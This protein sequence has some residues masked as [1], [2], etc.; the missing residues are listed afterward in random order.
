MFYYIFTQFWVEF[1][2]LGTM[3]MIVV[4]ITLPMSG[5]DNRYL[6]QYVGLILAEAFPVTA[7]NLVCAYIAG[8]IPY[9]NAAFNVHYF[10]GITLG[11]YYI[12][13]A[14]IFSSSPSVKYFWAWL[15]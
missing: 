1:F 7:V 10:W 3:V 5:W 6:G 15:S 13:D 9:A 2:F 4:L 11:G 12:T 8:S 14:F